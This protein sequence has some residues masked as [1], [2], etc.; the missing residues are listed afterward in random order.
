[1][2]VT[3]YLYWLAQIVGW[4]CYGLII[5]LATYARNP[6]GLDWIVVINILI[7]VVNAIFITHLMRLIY[8]KS[9]WLNMK[10]GPL[11]PRVLFLSLLASVYIAFFNFVYDS[12][13]KTKLEPNE[14]VTLNFIL[15]VI[16]CGILIVFWNGFYFSYHF[17]S[18]S[19]KQE[20]DNVSLEMSK[21]EFELKNLRSQLN[22][23]FLFNALNSIKALIDIEPKTA[24]S[25]VTLLAQLMRNSLNMGKETSVNLS[26]ELELVRNYLD[27][28]K[29]RFEDRVNVIW[30]VQEDMLQNKIPPFLLQTQVENAIKHGIS[31][32]IEGGDIRIKIFTEGHQNIYQ[33][34]NTGKLLISDESGIGVENSKKRLNLQYPNRNE[35]SLTQIKEEVLAQI[36]IENL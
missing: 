17:F 36:I 35:F 33:I 25:S 19:K 15:D 16:S 9:G 20:L 5:G 10:L 13:T 31:R 24:K 18:K 26:D 3:N 1:M 32:K 8:L 27:L 11:I 30:E 7:I 4:F 6:A 22:P 23:H 21:N 14:N 29:L 28:E 2:R 12:F 34:W